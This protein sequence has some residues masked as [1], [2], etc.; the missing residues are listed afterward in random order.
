MP[1]KI[2]ATLLI[3]ILGLSLCLSIDQTLLSW[4]EDF[5]YETD[6]SEEDMLNSFNRTS[7]L[8]LPSDYLLPGDLSGNKT[9]FLPPPTQPPKI[10]A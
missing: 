1:K 4:L 8:L 6:I 2:I 10:F 7:L 3:V 9:P 5:Q